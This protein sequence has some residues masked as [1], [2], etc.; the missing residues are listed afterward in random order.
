MGSVPPKRNKGFVP[1]ILTSFLSSE[2]ALKRYISR[3]LYRPED[4]DDLA[5]EAFLRAY[6]AAGKRSME[7]PKAYLYKVAKSIALKELAR[8]SR[9]LT[10]YL[11][12]GKLPEPEHNGSVDQELE[13]EQRLALYCEAIAEMPPQCR[14]VFLLRKVQA[15]SH[16]EIA[17]QLNISI[18]AVERNVTRAALKFKQ[19]MEEKDNEAL[20]P[21]GEGHSYGVYSTGGGDHGE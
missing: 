2:R 8:K 11:E 13:A 17:A 19:F 15:M 6:S 20:N 4:V 7:F 5:Q 9:Q 1:D 10:D 16:K 18:S 3:F 12:E 14:R 21:L